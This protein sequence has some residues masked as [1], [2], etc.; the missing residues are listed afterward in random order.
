MFVER[1]PRWEVS[2][3]SGENLHLGIRL[4]A[5]AIQRLAAT[6]VVLMWLSG[7]VLLVMRLPFPIH[8]ICVC[9]IQFPASGGN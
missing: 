4:T 5:V 2:S 9:L 1:A 6:L 7:Q 8:C 3:L